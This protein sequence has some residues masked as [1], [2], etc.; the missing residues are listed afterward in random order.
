MTYFE[1]RE[2]QCDYCKEH[3]WNDNQTSCSGGQCSSAWDEMIEEYGE[4][5]EEE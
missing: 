5:M 3:L 4:P 1:M 2:Y